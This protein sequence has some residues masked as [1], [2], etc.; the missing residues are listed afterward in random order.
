MRSVFFGGVFMSVF[1]S[2][3]I[4]Y[5]FRAVP[6]HLMA[7]Y[8]FRGRLR[9]PSWMA[10]LLVGLLQL[11]QALFY[12]YD[13]WRGGSGLAVSHGF[14]PVYMAIYFYAV[15]DDRFKALFLY[16]LVTDYTIIFRGLTV[17]LEAR[18]FYRSDMTFDSWTSVAF[19]LAVLAVTAPFMFRFSVTPRK[20]CSTPTP[21]C[22]GRRRGSSR[23]SIQ[24]S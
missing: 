3:V 15:R 23:C 2:A 10:A 18:F 20:R 12:G 4:N 22:S 8:P 17:F 14:S 7:Y 24:L 11:G 19:S 9:V 5:V 16:L 1:L 6:A 21:L 13:I